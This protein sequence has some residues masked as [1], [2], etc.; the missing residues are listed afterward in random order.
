MLINLQACRMRSGPNLE[1]PFRLFCA[2]SRS[3]PPCLH[4]HQ[5]WQVFSH[6]GTLLI[7][8]HHLSN[9][10]TTLAVEKTFGAHFVQDLYQP[11]TEY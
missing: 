7:L 1:V 2:W 11:S 5:H 3:H 4:I 9:L 8:S 6:S 10:A